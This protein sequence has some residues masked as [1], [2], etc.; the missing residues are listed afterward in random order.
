MLIGVCGYSCEIGSAAIEELYKHH[1]IKLTRDPEPPDGGRPTYDCVLFC[2]GHTYDVCVE[3]LLTFVPLADSLVVVTSEHGTH[4]TGIEHVA[5][6]A[7]KAAQ[8]MVCK[9]I[10]KS[11][12][13]CVDISP[14]FVVD[15][16]KNK[17]INSDRA[18][19]DKIAS[20]CVGE[21]PVRSI[22]VAKAIVFAVENVK[23]LSGSTI[24]V[25]AGWRV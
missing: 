11:G 14:A 17:R 23:K 3:K 8:K 25:S 12:K 22:D 24:T 9:C 20:E 13:P 10:A 4:P 19:R 16:G 15:S 21:F 1:E 7:V 18:Y 2:A 5:Y 6:Q